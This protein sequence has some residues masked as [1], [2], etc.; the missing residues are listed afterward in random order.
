[1]MESTF[2]KYLYGIFALLTSNEN[3]W[4]I[5]NLIQDTTNLKVT[6]NKTSSII[7]KYRFHMRKCKLKNE[8]ER[9]I[10]ILQS[11]ICNKINYNIIENP[12]TLFYPQI[13]SKTDILEDWDEDMCCEYCSKARSFFVVWMYAPSYQI[14]IFCDHYTKKIN[15]IINGDF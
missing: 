11:H 10:G 9:N 8:L 6:T 5:V 7:W 15:L 13:M 2:S 12:L 3:N 1:M 4:G 14:L